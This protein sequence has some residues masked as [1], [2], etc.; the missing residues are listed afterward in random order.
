MLFKSIKNALAILLFLVA[1]I[2]LDTKV[3]VAAIPDGFEDSLLPLD[4]PNGGGITGKNRI[5]L[6]LCHCHCCNIGSIH[7]E[8]S[9][10]S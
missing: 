7:M 4:I 6:I 9:V 3:I 10:F 8:F 1:I 5:L 2:S